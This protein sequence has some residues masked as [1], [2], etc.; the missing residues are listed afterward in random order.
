MMNF[1]GTKPYIGLE[2]WK[3]EVYPYLD[4]GIDSTLSR[5]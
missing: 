3:Q 4:V 1:P 5:T 2:E